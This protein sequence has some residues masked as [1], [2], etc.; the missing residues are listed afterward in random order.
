[1]HEPTFE[2]VSDRLR[3][4]GTVVHGFLQRMVPGAPRLPEETAIRAAL[5][6]AGVSPHELDSA[7]KRVAQALRKTMASEKGRWILAA[8]G[9]VRTEY[10]LTARVDGEIVR[11]LIDR[12]F[13]D[14]SGV[15]WVIDFKT[16]THEGANLDAFLDEEQR[17]YRDQMERYARIL[18]PLGRPVRLGLYF[19][20]L[21]AW[22]EWSA[23][24]VQRA[25]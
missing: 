10:A 21:D 2:W 14:E 20:L 6:H 8:H 18:R 7:S 17:R 25:G 13:V 1:M 15:R 5:R 9:E 19:P 3:Q 23:E 22:R 11:G 24:A 12:T 16:S 4:A